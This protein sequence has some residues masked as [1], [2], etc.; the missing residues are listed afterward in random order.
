MTAEEVQGKLSA[1]QYHAW[2]TEF[3]EEVHDRTAE[4]WYLAQLAL[5]VDALR[6]TVRHFMDP[7]PPRYEAKLEDFLLSFGGDPD[8]GLGEPDDPPEPAEETAEERDERI[9]R[10]KSAWLAWAGVRPDGTFET[11]KPP[12]KP[13]RDK[14]ADGGR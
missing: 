1:R 2:L 10:S 13:S 12:P 11:R 4:H 5:L 7:Q 14:G 9:K 6:H 8:G 3:Q